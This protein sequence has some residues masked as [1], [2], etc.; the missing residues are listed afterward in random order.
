MDYILTMKRAHD[1]SNKET[2]RADG[3]RQALVEA[4]YH[5]IAHYGLNGLR[6][7][8][9]AASAGMTHATLHYYFATK[10]LLIQAVIE[11][12]VFQRLLVYVPHYE[13]GDPSEGL[14]TF[15]TALSQRIQEDPTT[16]LVLY[17]LLRHGSQDLAI[18]NMFLQQNI[19]GDWHRSLASLLRA[20]IEQGQFRA[21]LDPATIASLL[22]I[23]LLGLGMTLLAPLPTPVEPIIDQIECWLHT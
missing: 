14:H 21:D 23:F 22:M 8:E 10:D 19:Y 17:D 5:S 6:T 20:G 13:E 16:F 15:L 9:V 7:R 12:A 11:Y 1:D 2:S 4:A 18:R 3:R